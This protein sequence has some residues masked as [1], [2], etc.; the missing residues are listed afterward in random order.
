MLPSPLL[1]LTMLMLMLW[2]TYCLFT[3]TLCALYIAYANGVDTTTPIHTHTH[4]RTH[5]HCIQRYG[6]KKHTRLKHMC[7]AGGDR[8]KCASTFHTT[9]L[10]ENHRHRNH[11]QTIYRALLIYSKVLSFS[12]R[13]RNRDHIHTNTLSL[14]LAHIVFK[15]PADAQRQRVPCDGVLLPTCAQWHLSHSPCVFLSK[16]E[17][18]RA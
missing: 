2:I 11:C 14:S 10:Y 3:R 1:L 18:A 9:K 5:S 16:R 8:G 4:T 15:Q 17:R 12:D 7:E 13:E 6:T